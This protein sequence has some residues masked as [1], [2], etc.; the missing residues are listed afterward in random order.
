[1]AWGADLHQLMNVIAVFL[2]GGLGA[3]ARWG[4]SLLMESLFPHSSKAEMI[5]TLLANIMAC[6]ILGVVAAKTMDQRFVLLLAVG[7]CGGFS[8]FSTFSHELLAMIK[9]GNYWVAIAYAVLSIATGMI[10][11]VVGMKWVMR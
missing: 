7:F 6:L 3:I 9:M 10:A 4:T 5:G 2:R 8:T 1:M 11:L